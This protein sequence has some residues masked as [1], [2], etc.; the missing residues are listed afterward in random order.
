L[1]AAAVVAVIIRVV[2][3]YYQRHRRIKN[4]VWCIHEHQGW[5]G[6]VP[7]AVLD[8]T[9]RLFWRWHHRELGTYALD[10][11]VEYRTGVYGAVRIGP[12]GEGAI[13]ISA[14][15]HDLK[16]L[17]EGLRLERREFFFSLHT[18][19][20]MLF[21]QAYQRLHGKNVPPETVNALVAE[22]RTAA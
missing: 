3:E 8:R 2:F 10:P 18:P 11:R 16:Y 4:Q 6:L 21:A 22:S 15:R 5:I 19:Q 9:S 14:N 12:S 17:L 1:V 13:Y 20:E 7:R